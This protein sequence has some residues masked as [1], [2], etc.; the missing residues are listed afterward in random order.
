MFRILME[1]LVIFSFGL[2]L[3][4]WVPVAF[5][6]EILLRLLNRIEKKIDVFLEGE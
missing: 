5:V 2:L 1:W 4:I 3:I 6:A